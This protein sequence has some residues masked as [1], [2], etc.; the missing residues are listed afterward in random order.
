MVSVLMAEFSE[1]IL[2]RGGVHEVLVQLPDRRGHAI[3][4][5]CVVVAHPRGCEDKEEGVLQF[6]SLPS[7]SSFVLLPEEL[8]GSGEYVTND[9]SS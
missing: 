1:Q 3:L 2:T 4:L 9:G 7:F 6:A 5:E 8:Q